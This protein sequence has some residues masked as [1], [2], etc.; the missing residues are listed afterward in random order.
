MY[1][2][3]NSLFSPNIEDDGSGDHLVCNDEEWRWRTVQDIRDVILDG[4]DTVPTP[5]LRRQ[6]NAS[7]ILSFYA[8]GFT[9]YGAVKVWCIVLLESNFCTI[10]G[11]YGEKIKHQDPSDWMSEK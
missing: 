4:A 10:V 3:V 7:L 11:K 8:E 1:T 6:K 5:D 9:K 2:F